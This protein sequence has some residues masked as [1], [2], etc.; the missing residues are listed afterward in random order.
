MYW[1]FIVLGVLAAGGIAAMLIITLP[2]SKKVYDICLVRTE[3]E[4]WP[5]VCSAP[6][7]EEQKAMW[8]EGCRWADSHSSAMREV[9][10]ETEGLRLEGE[11]YDFGGDRCV[12][13]FPG[14]CECLK[15]SYYYAKP[16]ADAGISVLVTDPRAHGK[17][18]GVYSTVGSAEGRDA[19]AWTHYLT[20]SCGMRSVYYPGVCIG[21]AAAIFAAS[22]PDCPDEVRG[23]VTEGCF[24]NFRE[25]FKNHMIIDKR[26]LF[27]VLDMVMIRLWVATGVN[28]LREC[29]LKAVS[30]L[31]RPALFIFGELDPYSVPEKSRRLFAACASDNKKDVWLP[32]GGHSHLRINNTEAYDKAVGDF[33]GSL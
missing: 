20:E 19:I 1:I 2:I 11:L 18:E 22:S 6:E 3:P 9:S 29:P 7:N 26:P 15:Y 21:G 33:I 12:V 25:T 30:R 8:D 14:R 16:Y 28:V 24:V 10:I 17:S 4:K 23:I 13:I 32:R 27:P 5:R 31:E